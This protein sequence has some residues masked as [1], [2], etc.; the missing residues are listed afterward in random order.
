M[1]EQ[2][3]KEGDIIEIKGVIGKV[4]TIGIRC[5]I[6]QTTTNHSILIPR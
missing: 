4:K 3:I 6:L 2:P 5:I 1:I